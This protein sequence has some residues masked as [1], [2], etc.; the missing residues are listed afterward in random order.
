MKYEELMEEVDDVENE[1]KTYNDACG[2]AM[3]KIHGYGWKSEKES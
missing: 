3:W 1:W 2:G